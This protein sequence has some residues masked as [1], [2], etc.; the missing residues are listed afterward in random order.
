MHPRDIART[1]PQRTAVVIPGDGDTLAEQRLSYAELVTATDRCATFLADMGLKPG[2][3]IALCM[4]NRLEYFVVCWAAFNLGLYFTP[5]SSRLKAREIAY[6][7]GDSDARAFFTSAAMAA[8]V[9]EL[10][11][12]VPSVDAW[13]MLDGPLLEEPCEGY[14]SCEQV[15]ADVDPRPAMAAAQGA[16]MM[17]TS[18]TTGFPKGVKPP[19]SELPVDEPPPLLN[20]LGRLYGFNGDTIYLSTGPLYHAAPLKFN[21]AVQTMG[22][23][24]VILRKFDPELSLRA[25][26]QY[27]VTH[28]QWVPTMFTRLMRLPGDVRGQYD[29]GS[30]RVAIHAAAPCPVELKRDM[31]A[32]WGP[33]IHEYY[34]GSE[35]VGMCAIGPEEWLRHQ[36]SV[37]KAVKGEIHILDRNEKEVP[38]GEAGLVFFANGGQF[39]YH[40][41]A[42]KTARAHNIRG[43]ATFGDIGYLDGEGYLYLTDRRD[44]VINSGGVNIYP[45]EA[46]NVL[47]QHPE[48]EDVAVF[49]IPNEEFG[50][51]VK[52]VVQPV[53]ASRAGPEFERELLEFCASKL[54][55][56]KCPKSID[57]MATMPREPTGKLLKRKLQE[58]YR[59]AAEKAVS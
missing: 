10:P 28:S 53:V 52:A 29:L 50:E 31:L 33:I 12:L 19:Q 2:D 51:E 3:A 43:W 9:R 18:G 39:V 8:E 45:Q 58:Q 41:D 11:A 20:L 54:A 57:F 42:D 38:P 17:Y 30:H 24:T 36:G 49:G 46:E 48:V 27:R 37:G 35:S 21:M 55:K 25:I 13:L 6:I 47:S 1:H 23:T 16:P 40:K 14:Q 26:A 34:A 56:L 59:K 5:I 7:L 4:E 22:G 15:L 32:W 44:Y